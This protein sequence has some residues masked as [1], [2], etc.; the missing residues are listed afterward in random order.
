MIRI[1]FCL[2]AALAANA[3]TPLFEIPVAGHSN[4]AWTTVRGSATPDAAVLHEA[5]KSLRIEPSTNVPDACVRSAPI[6]LTI[7]KTYELT[8]W[9]RT[10]D[11]TVRDVDRSPIALGA[12]LSMTSMPFDVH[13]ASVGG[14]HDWTR[15][16]LRF[17]ASRAQDQI[18]LTAGCHLWTRLPVP[19]RRLDLPAYRG[20][21]V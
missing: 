10:E 3:A 6:Q 15:L 4:S 18:L 21:A 1:A 16:S 11:L 5:K 7:G 2:L 9:V 13:S 20:Q 14:T 12:T 17:V 8:G 19:C